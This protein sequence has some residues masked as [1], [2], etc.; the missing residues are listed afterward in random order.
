MLDKCNFLGR[1][2]G[3]P[4][5]KL[6]DRAIGCGN[7]ALEPAWASGDFAGIG[8]GGCEHQGEETTGAQLP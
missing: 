4:V 6:I 2:S 1:E 3:E 5:N 7:V 8:M